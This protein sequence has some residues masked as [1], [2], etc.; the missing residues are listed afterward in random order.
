VA[1]NLEEGLSNSQCARRMGITEREVTA[2]VS[3][4]MAITPDLSGLQVA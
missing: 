3:R 2:A 4:I 1:L